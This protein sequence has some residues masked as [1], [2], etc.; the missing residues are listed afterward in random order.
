MNFLTPLTRR[1]R[2]EENYAVFDIE[3][4]NW[5]DFEMLGFFDGVDFTIFDSVEDFLAHVL[6]KNYRGIR[7]YAHNGGNFDFRFLLDHLLRKESKYEIKLLEGFG[8]IR[9]II[10]RDG[11]KHTWTFADSFA[12]LPESL[13]KLTND[14]DVRHK[15]QEVDY[16]RISR[17]SA[18]DRDYLRHDC[19]GLYEV[20]QS[21][22]KQKIFCGLKV[23][24]TTASNAM[25]MFRT[26]M[27]QELK[28]LNRTMEEFVRQTYFGGRVEIFRMLGKDINHYDFNSLYP[29]VMRNNFVPTGFPVWVR[30]FY[31]EYAGFY[32]ASV[33]YPTD[34]YIP[35]L[36]FVHDGR[37]VFPVGTF[38]GFFTSVE[39]LEAQKQGAKF[40]IHKGIIFKVQKKIFTEFIDTFF[41]MKHEAAKG[42]CQYLISK[43]MLNSCY[44]KFG[45]KRE[46]ESIVRCSLDEAI[47]R[48]LTEYMPEFSLYKEPSLCRGGYILP[49]I[50]SW[51]TAL[52]R[53]ELFRSLAVC[54]SPYYCDTD[55]I[56]T[57]SLLRTG[58]GLGEFKLEGS[59]KEA[60]FL[61]PKTYAAGESKKAKGFTRDMIRNLGYKD[62]EKSLLKGDYSPFNL[63]ADSFI[64]IKA[65]LKRFGKA[66]TRT[67]TRKSI[68]SAYT[69]RIV[70]PDLNTKPLELNILS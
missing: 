32:N 1:K 18:K 34:N 63:E 67:I 6:T 27:K 7:I 62:Y 11:A 52:A 48:R 56:F 10:V 29:S 17:K 60:V 66:C 24:G 4:N 9:E 15:K 47:K 45:Q 31:P 14:F 20:L 3:S 23:R 61:R 57:K 36:P 65:S 12:L 58:D 53:V 43:L 42:S 19:L 70:L 59:Y 51:I 13:C 49:H 68:K 2:R 41:K 40:K 33:S 44:G 39:M 46:R 35:C 54:A 37:L 30:D 26:T 55:S 22:F 64:G 28:G 50:A 21:F 8:R 5:T 38:R 16:S 69:K 25:M